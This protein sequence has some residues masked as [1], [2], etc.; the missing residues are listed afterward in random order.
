MGALLSQQA[1]SFFTN[2]AAGA[3]DK[4]NLPVRSNSW[5]AIVGAFLV[6]V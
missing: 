1:R 2:T 4:S 6:V 5:V 3:A